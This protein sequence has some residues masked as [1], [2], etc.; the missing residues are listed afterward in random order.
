MKVTL[1][2]ATEIVPEP[3]N[4]Y[5]T[6]EWLDI[7]PGDTEID[8]LA[9]FAGRACYQSFHRPNPKTAKNDGYIE[10]ILNQQHF[11]VFGHASLTF[12]AE[13]VSRALTHE[14]IRHRFLVFSELSQRYVD[15]TESYTVIPP[16]FAGDD[17]EAWINEHH[18]VSVDLY[19]RLIE[20][21]EACGAKTRKEARE[22]ARCVLPGG[23]ETKIVV[24][25]N[26]RAW[27]DFVQQR[28]S[29]HADAEI[30]EFAGE[31]LDHLQEY[32]P[33]SVK[34]LPDT[35]YE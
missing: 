24:S 31:I 33:N 7:G 27:R 23:T 18:R 10:N 25:G 4:E 14:M 21:A 29:E 17:A 13:G 32:A 35:P 19:D 34:D 16:L 2:A 6:L 3:Y 20:R 8:H 30:R 1:I 26:I 5:A 9:E 11:S 12:Y 22:A 15:M 28:W